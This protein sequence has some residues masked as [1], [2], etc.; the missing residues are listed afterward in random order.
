[1][2]KRLID[3]ISQSLITT[4]ERNEKRIKKK[5]SKIDLQA[6]HVLESKRLQNIEQSPQDEFKE[7]ERLQTMRE[8]LVK[9]YK[10]KQFTVWG[11]IYTKV[12]LFFLLVNLV[13]AIVIAGAGFSASLCTV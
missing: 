3:A 13:A 4:K 9:E 8:N 1:M 2:L 7:Q 6:S 5:I 12:C 11:P 10:L